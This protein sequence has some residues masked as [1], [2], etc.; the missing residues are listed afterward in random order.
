MINLRD[1]E[2]KMLNSDYWVDQEKGKKTNGRR[3]AK[4]SRYSG[5]RN[6][7]IT[8]KWGKYQ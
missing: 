2:M 5:Y 8:Y 4:E 1:S 7:R 6:K 3:Y